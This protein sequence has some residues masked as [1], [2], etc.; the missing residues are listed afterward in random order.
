MTEEQLNDQN[1]EEIEEQ[2]EG[3]EESEEK[4]LEDKLKEVIDVNVEELEG[5]R[6]KLT[7]TVPRDT[8]DGQ[9]QEQ[10]EELRREAMVPGFRKGRAP[11][12]LLE[13][14]FGNEVSETLVQQLV[15]TGY[16]A[17]VDKSELKTI[18]DPLIFVKSDKEG[19]GEILEEVQAAI[20]KMDLPP[21]GPLVFACE[22]E[23]RPEFALPELADIALEQP[24]LTVSDEDVTTQINHF[25][26]MRGTYESVPE[27]AVEA[28]DVITANLK[29]TADGTVLKEQSDARFAARPQV[30]DGVV[31]EKLG[32]TLTGAKVG[33][34]V[35]I[36]GNVPDDYAKAEYRGKEAT[37]EIT[38]KEIQRLRRPE[39]N[40]EFVKGFGFE[41]VDE[42]R[43]WIRQ[44]LESR[45][46]EEVK[47]MMRG[48]VSQYLM[49]NITFDLPE[50]L[51]NR[52]IAQ[53]T[54][55]RI[56]EMYRRGIPP[57]EAEKQ[58]DQLRTSSR[59]D[60]IRDLKQA[61]IM[62]KLSEEIEVEVT[63]GEIN[64][65]I[66][67]IAQRQGQ[68]FDRVRDELARQGGLTNLY[69]RLRDEKIIDELIGK[70]KVTEAKLED[71]KARKKGGKK[72]AESAKDEKPTAKEAAEST[73]EPK[74]RE[75]VK[76]TP[77]KKSKK[78]KGENFADET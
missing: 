22:V 54:A 20:S 2:V 25:L 33:D 52:Q 4:S 28:D 67:A 51:S 77:P 1:M 38:I 50:R 58:L 47:Q 40:E 68:R 61:F 35:T 9:V 3:A 60:A 29:I 31:L 44:D 6:R 14:R 17:A 64:A 62:E 30:V 10:Y 78:D 23:I 75:Q 8:L 56:I 36:K 65:M 15:S 74:P 72:K 66:A 26:G 12:R 13:K 70:A 7:I 11:R 59:E 19:E 18:G 48:Q 5:L 53:V 34:T 46:G 55:S 73:E 21:E 39:L 63:E 43:E 76:R 57:A 49:D 71:I 45:L 27:D 32:E 37:F 42:M 69:V 24:I 41:T 16:M